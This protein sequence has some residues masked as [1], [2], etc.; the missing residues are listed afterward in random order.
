MLNYCEIA[1]GGNEK[2]RIFIR[3][4]SNRWFPKEQ[5]K[6]KTVAFAFSSLSGSAIY[7]CLI[8]WRSMHD[9]EVDKSR[10]DKWKNR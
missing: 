6:F 7:N 8:V 2:E 9:L 4:I 3:E 1:R 10:E 5:V